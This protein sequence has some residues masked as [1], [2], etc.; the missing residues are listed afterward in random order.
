MENLPSCAAILGSSTLLI[1][2][3]ALAQS[4]TPAPD[5]TNTHITHNGN[6]DALQGGTQAGANLF[7]RFEQFSLNAEEVGQFL[8]NPSIAN[9]LG[10]VVG[11][12]L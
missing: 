11:L 6:T 3:V 5:G 8:S 7:H 2:N 9:I 10:R 1:A 12:I 4:I